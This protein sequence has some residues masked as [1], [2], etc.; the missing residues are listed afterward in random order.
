MTKT[1]VARTHIKF[2]LFCPALKLSVPRTMFFEIKQTKRLLKKYS[3]P[4][5]IIFKC[6][7]IA[8]DIKTCVIVFKWSSFFILLS[9][10]CSNFHA[11][12]T[13]LWCF[14]Y[15]LQ[16]FWSYHLHIEHF[17]LDLLWFR[18]KWGLLWTRYH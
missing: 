18:V 15:N 14:G 13:N 11:Y 10:S 12:I 1:T 16:K 7:V 4:R 8:I 9:V 3:W 6:T 2:I 5:R 17:F